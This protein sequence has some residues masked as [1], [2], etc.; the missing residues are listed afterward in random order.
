MEFFQTNLGLL[1]G[2]VVLVV[3]WF[4][5]QLLSRHGRNI[6]SLISRSLRRPVL[7]GLG[8]SLYGTWITHWIDKR[9]D[10]VD[11]TTLNRLSATLLIL[12]ISWAALN[13]GHVILQSGSM[14]RWMQ[15]DDE[16]DKSML[17]NLLRRL[18]TILVLLITTAMLM[19]NFGIPSAAIATLLGGAGIGFTFATQQISQ[20]FL[21]GFM[22][23]FN[24]PFKEGDW[25]NVDEMQGTVESIGWY[26]TRIRTFDRR[27]LN[28][29]NSVFAT[30]PIENPGQMY[31][32]RILANISLRYEDIDKIAGVTE[33]VRDHLKHHPQ[34]D[35]TQII[36]VN[37][38]Q[39]DASSINM[40]VYCF[41]KTTA[42]AEWLSIQQSIFLD[43]AG[44]VKGR[45]ADFAFNCMTLYP[46]ATSHPNQWSEFLPQNA[47]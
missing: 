3:A 35:Q 46:A 36:L 24:R 40:M 5:L 29:P 13:V 45:G 47:S 33:E 14:R 25:I 12:T 8:V 44:I 10:L 18:F 21:S 39:W 16:Q 32:R 27:P 23:F 6:G 31:N 43:I 1:V 17:I 11:P 22:L 7:I 2:T 37:F 4:L 15:M 28:I 26:Y 42:W 41:T 19:V 34:I 20:N 38:N 30:K 9:V